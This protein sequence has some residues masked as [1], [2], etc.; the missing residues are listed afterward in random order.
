MP[1]KNCQIE[2][3]GESAMDLIWISCWQ[4]FNPTAADRVTMPDFSQSAIA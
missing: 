3:V 2:V 1:S 4:S